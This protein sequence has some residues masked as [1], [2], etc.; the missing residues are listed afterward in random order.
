M[1]AKS[2][3]KTDCFVKATFVT[4]EHVSKLMCE[5]KSLHCQAKL[6]RNK[7]S[8]LLSSNRNGRTP[9]TLQGSEK[10]WNVQRIHSSYDVEASA[11]PDREPTSRSWTQSPL[12]AV[13]DSR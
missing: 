12:T 4:K 2:A 6:R 5:G 11:T 8:L 3:R 7:H 10:H 13:A 1:W 9:E